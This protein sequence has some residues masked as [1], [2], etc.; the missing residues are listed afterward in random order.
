MM[1]HDSKLATVPSLSMIGYKVLELLRVSRLVT[2]FEADHFGS[3]G[4]GALIVT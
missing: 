4:S 1:K 3:E 2:R